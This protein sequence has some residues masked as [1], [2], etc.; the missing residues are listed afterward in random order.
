[1][2][3]NRFPIRIADMVTAE[4]R[5]PGVASGMQQIRVAIGLDAIT[6]LTDAATITID[7]S[8]SKYQQ[9]TLA[10]NRTIAFSN[11]AVGQEIVLVLKQDGTGSRTI[12]WPSGIKWSGGSAPT[13]TTTASKSDR[14]SIHCVATG[15]YLATSALNF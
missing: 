10:G 2:G 8:Q 14:I 12:T 11:V 9:V 4:G 3:Q 6:T 5:V 13:L 1:M 7:W 15:A